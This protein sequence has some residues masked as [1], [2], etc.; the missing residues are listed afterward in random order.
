MPQMKKI[1]P[2]ERP[3]DVIKRINAIFVKQKPQWLEL[4][5]CEKENKYKVYKL[6]EGKKHGKERTGS[7]LFKCVEKSGFCA[8]HCLP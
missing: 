7:K 1:K 8:R 5:G 6:K 2:K 3:E 4:L